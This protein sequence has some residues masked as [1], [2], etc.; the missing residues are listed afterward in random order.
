MA[1]FNTWSKHDDK[2]AQ[3]QVELHNPIVNLRVNDKLL[4]SVVVA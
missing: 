4:P 3:S 2:Q 1:T